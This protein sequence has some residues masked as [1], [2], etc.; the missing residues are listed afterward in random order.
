MK[1]RRKQKCGCVG[2]K[3]KLHQLTIDKITIINLCA[4]QRSWVLCWK[5]IWR[6]C[7]CCFNRNQ[8]SCYFFFFVNSYC[9]LLMREC[10]W[11]KTSECLKKFQLKFSRSLLTVA[12]LC[13]FSCAD[14]CHHGIVWARKA[15]LYSRE[16]LT[17]RGK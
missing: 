17:S 15:P 3:K 2:G 16:P 7:V 6:F 1:I 14:V 9:Q 4:A 10:V 11:R 5:D 13:R 12:E 8:R